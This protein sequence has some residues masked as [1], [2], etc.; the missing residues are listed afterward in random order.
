MRLLAQARNP[1][2]R[3]WLWI[4][5]SRCARPGM[6][7]EGGTHTFAFTRRNASEFCRIVPPLQVRGRRE[8]RVRAAPAVSCAMCTEK[9]AHEHTGSA[10]T[11]R[12]SPRNGFTA[13]SVLSLVIGFLATI[14]SRDNPQN[15]TPASGRRNHTSSPYASRA[16]RQRHIRV[17]R[18]PSRV[19]DD[20]ERPSCRDEMGQASISDLPDQAE[21]VVRQ[22][23]GLGSKRLIGRQSGI[24]VQ[25]VSRMDWMRLEGV[26]SARKSARNSFSMQAAKPLK[27]RILSTRVKL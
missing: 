25:K 15:L 16:V 23:T 1:Y 4:P 19:R 7:T 21:Q 14:V 13:Y 17:H 8:S 11:L 12:P 18:I 10:E 22:T 9:C 3:S 6:T 2:S 24:F 20:R 27:P 5:G 26:L